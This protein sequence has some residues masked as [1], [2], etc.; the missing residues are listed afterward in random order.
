MAA[1]RR[2]LSQTPIHSALWIPAGVNTINLAGQMY[3]LLSNLLMFAL[4]FHIGRRR[5]TLLRLA[6]LS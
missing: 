3:N 2:A 1:E 6:G 5:E 4:K